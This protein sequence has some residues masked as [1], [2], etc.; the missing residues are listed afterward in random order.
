[1]NIKFDSFL[2]AKVFMKSIINLN[3]SLNMFVFMID[4]MFEC[5]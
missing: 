1:M 4:V 5:T 3:F 2:K